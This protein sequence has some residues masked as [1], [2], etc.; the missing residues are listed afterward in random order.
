[1]EFGGVGFAVVWQMQDTT[2]A[3]AKSGSLGQTLRNG[4][5]DLHVIPGP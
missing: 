4:L 2:H 1:M 5:M 3:A